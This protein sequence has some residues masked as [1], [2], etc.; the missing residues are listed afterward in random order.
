MWASRAGL[1]AAAFVWIYIA[2]MF[3]SMSVTLTTWGAVVYVRRPM[4]SQPPTRYT[5]VPPRALPCSSPINRSAPI[6]RY[7]TN[8][9]TPSGPTHHSFVQ[10]ALIC[11]LVL[12]IPKLF[13]ADILEHEYA[14]EVFTIHHIDEF[15]RDA[16][17][18]FIVTFAVYVEV[19]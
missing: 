15:I 18:E 3:S 6:V 19:R 2:L 14:R 10:E 8:P 1:G 13:I 12:I 11:P 17:H 16:I 4:P 7:Q 5:Q 9:G